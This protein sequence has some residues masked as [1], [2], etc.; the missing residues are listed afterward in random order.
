M[1]LAEKLALAKNTTQ[2]R[3]SGFS[4]FHIELKVALSVAGF[5]LKEEAN[6]YIM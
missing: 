4:V 5:C 3:I 1:D 2:K 6:N